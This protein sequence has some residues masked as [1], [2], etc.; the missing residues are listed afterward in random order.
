[1]ALCITQADA[2]TRNISSYRTDEIKEY[3]LWHC[4]S[5]TPNPS[6]LPDHGFKLSSGKSVYSG[7]AASVSAAMHLVEAHN[8][9]IFFVIYYQLCDNT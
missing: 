8:H 6:S 3:H 1:M 2:D 9:Y 5:R 4:A 7:F